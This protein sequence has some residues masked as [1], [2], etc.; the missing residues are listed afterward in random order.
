MSKQFFTRQ[1]LTGAWRQLRAASQQV[2]RQNAH[3]LLLLYSVECG[4][5]AVWLKRESRNL[6]TKDDID[7]TGHDLKKIM[8]VIGCSQGLPEALTMSDVLDEK[9]NTVTRKNIGSVDLHQV[10]RYGGA[11]TNPRP[12]DQAV[13]LCLEDIHSWI[14]KELT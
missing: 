14:E 3:R 12:D 1:E 7:N 9:R 6:F 2:H 10:W 8:K 11:L 5:K 13:E 4:L